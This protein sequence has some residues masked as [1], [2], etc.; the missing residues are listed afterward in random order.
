MPVSLTNSTLVDALVVVLIGLYILED[1]R[2]GI[3]YGLVQLAGLLLALLAALLLYS[4][5]ASELVARLGLGYGLAKP[6]AFGGVWLASDLL[7]S[8]TVRQF[9]ARAT[10]EVGQ[11]TT[12]R[13]LGVATG[14]ARGAVV[15][16]LLLAIVAALPL[17]EPIGQAIEESSL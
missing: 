1:V 11:S 10:P 12:R 14:L 13:V 4:V 3:L 16:M 5:V 7:Y 17:P 2:N 6:I 15:A 9:T 8:I